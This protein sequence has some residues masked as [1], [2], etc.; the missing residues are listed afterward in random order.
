VAEPTEVEAEPEATV[1]GGARVAE[2]TEGEAEPEA[3]VE[4]QRPLCG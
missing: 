2:P 1:E 3:T 4:G